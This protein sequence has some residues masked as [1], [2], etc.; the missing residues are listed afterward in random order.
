MVMAQ[1]PEKAEKAS[2]S[3]SS[4]A[5][6][7]RLRQAMK[8]TGGGGGGGGEGAESSPAA[9]EGDWA[10]LKILH[11]TA[12]LLQVATRQSDLQISAVRDKRDFN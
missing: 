2:S 11:H 12:R 8:E 1:S 10:N 4:S 5:F 9:A 7:E 3:S 6:R